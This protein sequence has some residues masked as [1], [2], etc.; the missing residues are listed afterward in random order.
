MVNRKFWARCGN[1]LGTDAW[2]ALTSADGNGAGPVL[3]L[4]IGFDC[5]VDGEGQRDTGGDGGSGG[6]GSG[7]G[8][9]IG[10]L[11]YLSRG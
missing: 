9:G 11:G 3:P 4:K 1:G 10:P 6:I 7:E 2:V 8:E 5:S